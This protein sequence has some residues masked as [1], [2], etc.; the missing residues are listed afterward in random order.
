MQHQSLVTDRKDIEKYLFAK[1]ITSVEDQK[2]EYYIPSS[3]YVEK[4][5]VF[6]NPENREDTTPQGMSFGSLCTVILRSPGIKKPLQNLYL[7]YTKDKKMSG[8]NEINEDRFEV[9]VKSKV[10]DRNNRPLLVKLFQVYQECSENNWDGY[11]AQLIS[12]KAYFEAEK[13]IRLLPSHIKEPEIVPEPTG[14]IALEWYQGKRFTFVIS[15][16]GNNLITY[17]GLFGSTSKAHGTEY[18]GAEVPAM[19][20]E[21][22]QLLFERAK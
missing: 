5:C 6:T 15:V 10:A 12:K 11:D 7:E 2:N 1:S 19:I 9:Q 3:D 22:I 17:A 20:I 18:F 14:E 8:D 16:G 4:T 13:L 21:K